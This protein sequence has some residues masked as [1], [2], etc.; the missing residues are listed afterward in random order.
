M[1]LV[2]EQLVYLI[3]IIRSYKLLL[4]I[5]NCNLSISRLNYNKLNTQFKVVKITIKYLIEVYL[6]YEKIIKH[7]DFINA[8][9]VKKFLKTKKIF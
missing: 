7:F 8:T 4:N 3:N 2:Y 9:I 5:K 1:I 6:K